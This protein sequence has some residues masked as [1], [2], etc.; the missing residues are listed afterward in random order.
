MT[1]PA[2]QPD[3][4]EAATA[5]PTAEEIA[6]AARDEQR[7]NDARVH[8]LRGDTRRGPG[9][10]RGSKNKPKGQR[11]ARDA[12]ASSTVTPT[13]P[14]LGGAAATARA[15]RIDREDAARKA[16]RKKQVDEWSKLALDAAPTIVSGIGLAT[17]LPQQFLVAVDTDEEG[18]PRIDENGDPVVGLTH[19]GQAL[20]PKPW[21]VRTVAEAAARLTET[22]AGDKLLAFM[23]QFAPYGYGAA[24]L[25]ALGLYTVTV[26]KTVEAIKPMVRIE[27]EQAAAQAAE[28][29]A[30]QNDGG[31][32]FL[33]PDNPP[34]S[35]E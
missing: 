30:Q 34:G 7:D 3:P 15:A 27:M 1:N 33:S 22:E 5:E 4:V 21:Q 31:G 23:E 24:A 16:A 11:A 29:A 35:S 19:Y 26:L 25:A 9:R 14:K 2:E 12:A 10:P 20:A 18:R 6:A 17:G 32:D 28:Q 13:R 8:E